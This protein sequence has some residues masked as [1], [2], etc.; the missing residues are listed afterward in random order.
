MENDFPNKIESQN[1]LNQMDEEKNIDLKQKTQSNNS[2]VS[3]RP[4][5]NSKETLDIEPLD[6]KNLIKNNENLEKF[7][8][9]DPW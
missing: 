9:D 7:E 4:I 1:S 2:F 8:I 3:K 6:E 5:Q